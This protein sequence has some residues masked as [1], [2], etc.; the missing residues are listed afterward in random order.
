MKEKCKDMES[1]AQRDGRY[2]LLWL[3]VASCMCVH[4]WVGGVFVTQTLKLVITLLH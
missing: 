3:H 2:E 4:A 1:L